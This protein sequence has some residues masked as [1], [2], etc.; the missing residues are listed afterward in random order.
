[1]ASPL[2]RTEVLLH[3]GAPLGRNKGLR[4]ID[5]EGE[6]GWADIQRWRRLVRDVVDDGATGLAV[7]LRG[8][9]AIDSHCVSILEVAAETLTARGGG[10]SVV[11]FPGSGVARRLGLFAST[12]PTF[13]TASAALFSLA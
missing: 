7:D 2:S 8:C 12:L 1:M 9:R 6:L 13:D 11:V 5:V 10:V 3:L 4:L